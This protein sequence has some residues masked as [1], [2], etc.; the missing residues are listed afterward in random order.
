[1]PWPQATRMS[2]RSTSRGDGGVVAEAG[3]AGGAVEVVVD[4][5]VD[6]EFEGAREELLGEIDGQEAR[7]GVEGVVAE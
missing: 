1:M 3:I 7:A 4:D 2:L 6:G 5:S